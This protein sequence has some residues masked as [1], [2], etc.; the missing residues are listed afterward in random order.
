M[1]AKTKNNVE[2]ADVADQLATLRADISTL[3]STVSDLAKLKGAELSD[4]A[5]DQIASAKN[6]AA[7]QS[8]A[9]KQQAAQLQD[10][11][12]EF[13]RTQPATAVGMAAALG[14][15]IGMLMTRK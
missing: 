12:N 11:A 7:A 10:Q 2:P 1:N 14:F 3:T 15:V 5:K 6:V 4:A 8:E 9:A 13:V